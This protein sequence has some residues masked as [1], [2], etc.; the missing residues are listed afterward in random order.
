M[1]EA[2]KYLQ[3]RMTASERSAEVHYQSRV[4]GLDLLRALA[5]FFVVYSHGHV[6]LKNYISE[7]VY[8]LP[9]FDGVSIFFVLSGFL[10]GRILIRT[11]IPHSLNSASL[12]SFWLRRWIRTLPNYFAV[13]LILVA[14]LHF[15]GQPL[16]SELTQYFFFIQ[17]LITPH[18]QFFPEAW[19]LSVEEWFYLCVPIALYGLA[20]FPRLDR[21]LSLLTLIVLVI[22]SV[23]IFR[24]Y[25]A[26]S[27]DFFDLQIWDLTL[28]KQV[29]TRVDALMYG[30]LGAYLSLLHP[31]TWG[32][33]SKKAL[34]IGIGL[35]LIDKLLARWPST[36]HFYV[37]YFTLS[38]T[39]IATLLLLPV[40]STWKRPPDRF[41][42]I[43]T[44]VSLISYAMYLLNLSP[45]QGV[46]IPKISAICS[47][48][49]QN[50]VAMYAAY[51]IITISL[52]TLMYRYFER[53]ITSLRDRYSTAPFPNSTA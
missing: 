2:F 44:A 3:A 28:R 24:L 23:T 4:F 20:K 53:P 12:K 10:I 11:W 50:S 30:V 42:K 43:V 19:S 48:C 22:A 32:E 34:L 36:Q 1:I 26:S 29:V 41:T 52:S 51:W 6:F 37:T 49:S 35:F 38:V 27:A 7:P 33:I 5:I 15:S 31:A 9:I 40:L 47:N 39:S 8:T 13:L 16:P 25:R 46:L 45:I 17:N 14:S 18:P 21:R